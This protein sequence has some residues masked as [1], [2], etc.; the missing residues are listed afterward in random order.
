MGFPVMLTWTDLAILGFTAWTSILAIILTSP[1]AI[2]LAYWS[3]RS[4]SR[5]SSLLDSLATLPLAIPPVA[6]GLFL[7]HL[8]SVNQIPG[9]WLKSIG[10]QIPFTWR[11]VVLALSVMSFPL[12]YRPVLA[13]FEKLDHRYIKLS[14]SLGHSPVRTFF[15][16]TLPLARRGLVAGALLGWARAIGEFGA[17]IIIAGN[18]PGRTRTLSLAIFH[19]FQ[20]GHDAGALRLAFLTA[21][22]TVLL[23]YGSRRLEESTSWSN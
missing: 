23:V 21:L 9:N 6:A 20:M 16:T 3:S 22:L 15:N 12:V 8:L 19:R 7:L 13:T 1:V 10:V 18:I 2:V 4:R 14:K 5:F 17:T 11:A